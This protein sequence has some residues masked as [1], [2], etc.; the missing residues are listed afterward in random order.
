MSNKFQLKRTTTT[1]RTPNTTSSGNTAYIGAGEL[2]INLTDGKLFSSDGTNLITVG[3]NLSSLFVSGNTVVSQINATSIH[4]GANV[5][6][7]SAGISIGNGTVYSSLTATAA[8]IANI[9][10]ANTTSFKLIANDVL[11]FN[12]Q[13]TQN[14]AFRVYDAANTRIA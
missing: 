8:L 2:A 14:T 13:T 6:L 1:G 12:D 7:T 9:V 11:T 10:A 3:S 4:V 5:V